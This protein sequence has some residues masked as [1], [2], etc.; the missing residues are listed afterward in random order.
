[1]AKIVSIE[2]IKSELK[3]SQLEIDE[4]STNNEV[5]TIAKNFQ[6]LRV[7]NNE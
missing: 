3:V 6:V 2:N 5:K 7:S 4:M 1:M